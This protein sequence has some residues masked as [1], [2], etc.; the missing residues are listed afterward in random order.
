MAGLLVDVH[1]EVH[2]APEEAATELVH[3]VVGIVTLRQHVLQPIARTIR[4]TAEEAQLDFFLPTQS[5]TGQPIPNQLHLILKPSLF[6]ET[7]NDPNSLLSNNC[8]RLS[9]YGFDILQSA[10]FENTISGHKILRLGVVHAAYS[11]TRA[12]YSRNKFFAMFKLPNPSPR[13]S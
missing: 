3:R 6:V 7:A 11:L 12:M 13:K 5:F 9:F 1:L 10:G 8:K 2:V 4:S